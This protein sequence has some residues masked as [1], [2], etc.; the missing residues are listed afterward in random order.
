MLK[1]PGMVPALLQLL[2]PEAMRESLSRVAGGQEGGLIQA[3]AAPPAYESMQAVPGGGSSSS[4]T[5]VLHPL[6]LRVD[7]GALGASEAAGAHMLTPLGDQLSSPAGFDLATLS[8]TSSPHPHARQTPPQHALPPGQGLGLLWGAAAMA[9]T[10]CCAPARNMGSETEGTKSNSGTS[11]TQ[12][13]SVTTSSSLLVTSYT[14]QGEALAVSSLSAQILALAVLEPEAVP[15]APLGYDNKTL[16][17]AALTALIQHGRC[18]ATLDRWVMFM[19]MVHT[20]FTV[21]C[22]CRDRLRCS[23][24]CSTGYYNNH[25]AWIS[26][27]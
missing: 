17:T 11:S 3:L 7:P 27:G 19:L 13:S 10:S 14:A 5:A 16:L 9:A 2:G 26:L 1:L 25:T 23:T 15:L 21:W 4:S 24:S 22:S 12:Q 18:V 6:L 8:R 20:G